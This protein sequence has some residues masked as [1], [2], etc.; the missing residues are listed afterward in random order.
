M[1]GS[2][3]LGPQPTFYLSESCGSTLRDEVTSH[4]ARVLLSAPHLEVSHLF[5]DA[6]AQVLGIPVR[7]GDDLEAIGFLASAIADEVL[8]LRAFNQERGA[9]ELDRAI[10]L[11]DSLESSLRIWISHGQPWNALARAK[12]ELL[13]IARLG[14]SSAELRLTACVPFLT[15]SALMRAELSASQR[16]HSH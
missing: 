1:T 14:T 10:R 12:S 2:N 15:S 6:T 3:Q 5:R 16:D 4:L 13:R 11:I 8:S 9:D 7:D